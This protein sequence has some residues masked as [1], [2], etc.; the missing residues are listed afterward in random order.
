MLTLKWKHNITC[1]QVSFIV[2][3]TLPQIAYTCLLFAPN[4]RFT[5]HALKLRKLCSLKASKLTCM[6]K[7]IMISSSLQLEQVIKVL[8]G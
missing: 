4:F 2:T 1:M 7:N 6:H 3:V 8:I 5:P